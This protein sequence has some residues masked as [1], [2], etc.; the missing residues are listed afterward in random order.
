MNQFKLISKRY[1]QFLSLVLFFVMVTSCQEEE[2]IPM[3]S[4]DQGKIADIASDFVPF[5]EDNRNLGA[6]ATFNE[7]KGAIG[8][9]F[10][11]DFDGEVI[12]LN[13]LSDYSPEKA[14]YI[15]FDI[16][17]LKLNE[18]VFDEII[19][20]ASAN[21]AGLIFE[22]GSKN[23]E[24]MKMFHLTVFSN[25]ESVSFDVKG[26][27][28]ENS[29]NTEVTRTT[30]VSDAISVS[31]EGA[32]KTFL[33]GRKYAARTNSVTRVNPTTS[34]T[35]P[36]KQTRCMRGKCTT[37]W[38]TPLYTV[39]NGFRSVPN[40]SSSYDYRASSVSYSNMNSNIAE[41]GI[42][43]RE[44]I[45]WGDI[46]H[47][48]LLYDGTY[49]CDQSASYTQSESYSKS[50]SAGIKIDAKVDKLGSTL[51]NYLKELAFSAAGN[52]GGSHS[53]GS[54]YGT[55][56]KMKKRFAKTAVYSSRWVAN[57][58]YWKGNVTYN[59]QRKKKTGLRRTWQ[60]YAKVK[61]NFTHFAHD[62]DWDGNQPYAPNNNGQT[63]ILFGWH[64][65][66]ETIPNCNGRVADNP[67]KAD[68]AYWWN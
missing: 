9:S 48:A 52:I 66:G 58:G 5:V 45:K 25:D 10:L 60:T 32:V 43:D 55:S 36:D 35:Y 18:S 20:W 7:V 26:L 29:E 4:N 27:I 53:Q 38:G 11:N 44:V 14:G 17:R 41:W 33:A 3:A 16:D 64:T 56:I 47:D 8:E 65:W 63:Q 30:L 59:L 42:Q 34:V 2:D 21:H 37:T 28:I 49:N 23:H 15:H 12:V 61:S 46:T 24:A 54:G 68:Q 39:T 19:N 1:Y 57:L 13:K 62:N 31:A 51:K 6:I 50:W 67:A 22:S 40:S